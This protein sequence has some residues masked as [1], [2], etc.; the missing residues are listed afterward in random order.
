MNLGASFVV[1]KKDK[2]IILRSRNDYISQLRWISNKWVILYDI[3]DRRAWMVDG[4]STLLH[5]VRASL[6]HNK[7][8]LF[9]DVFL[10]DMKDLVEAPSDRLGKASAIS[11]LTNVKNTNLKL[12]QKS[13]ETFQEDTTKKTGETE[14]TKKSKSSYYCFKDRVDDICHIMEQLVTYQSQINSQDGVGFKVTTKS[15]RLLGGFD[16]MD[17]V[18]DEDPLWP[19]VVTLSPAGAGWLD[20]AQVMQAVVLFGRD[21]GELIRPSS[22]VQICDPWKSVPRGLDYLTIC[23]SDLK[24]IL[25]KRGNTG[26]NPWTLVDDIRWH[27]PRA[28]FGP[29]EKSKK[30]K[31][32]N[33]CCDRVQ[34]LV[35]STAPNLFTRTYNSPAYLED[36][37][38][39]I[40]GHNRKLSMP[41]TGTEEIEDPQAVASSQ[42]AHSTNDSG[43]GSSMESVPSEGSPDATHT[44]S[45]N[46]ESTINERMGGWI[47][48]LDR[49]KKQKTGH[50]SS[51]A[52]N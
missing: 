29:C 41:R 15:K 6:I 19:R 28:I 3:G 43:L 33:L 12:H 52:G 31:N 18:G 23:V 22:D 16:F 51:Q 9:S 4:V 24:E 25:K 49:R 45:G 17:I 48:R 13:S 21:F 20:F 36:E 34:V 14:E 32:K 50:G 39:V 8:D 7:N 42:D 30:G 26:I 11:V 38:A 46:I 37:G 2:P 44:A 35:P 1:G 40:F 10:F 27:S 47:L 5:L